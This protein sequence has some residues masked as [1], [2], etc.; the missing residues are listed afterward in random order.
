MFPISAAPVTLT[1]VE[2]KQA[3]FTAS[4]PSLFSLNTNTGHWTVKYSWERK[5]P[6]EEYYGIVQEVTKD[7]R[8]FDQKDLIGRKST[9]TDIFTTSKGQLDKSG[10]K[11]KCRIIVTLYLPNKNPRVIDEGHTNEVTWNVFAAPQPPPPP[12]PP[13]PPSVFYFANQLVDFVEVLSLAI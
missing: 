3:S 8:I 12:P 10:R 11:Y 2:G 5:I 7:T 4:I 1:L 13:P 9:T 6:G